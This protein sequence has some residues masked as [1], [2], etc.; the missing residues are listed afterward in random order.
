MAE[1]NYHEDGQVTDW[2]GYFQRRRAFIESQNQEEI[3]E[4][5]EFR[6]EIPGHFIG[7]DLLPKPI[8]DVAKLLPNTKARYSVTFQEGAVFKS[9]QKA[10]QKRPD[11]TVEH[12]SIGHY[13]PNPLTA[14]WSDGKLQYAKGFRKGQWYYT[15]KITELKRWTKEDWND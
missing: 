5:P 14:V 11:K 9:G 8:Y 6:V 3:E 12:Y 15:D 13:G 10:G 1:L 4:A 2:H 7:L